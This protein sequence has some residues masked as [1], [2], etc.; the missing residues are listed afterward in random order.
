MATTVSTPWRLSNRRSHSLPSSTHHPFSSAHRTPSLLRTPSLP[1]GCDHNSTQCISMT[2]VGI[3][4]SVAGNIIISCACRNGFVADPSD[5][6]RCLNA[7]RKI[8][9]SES[10]KSHEVQHAPSALPTLLP[11]SATLAPTLAPTYEPCPDGD[12]GCDPISTRCRSVSADNYAFTTC[13]CIDG[14]TQSSNST[15]RC[16]MLTPSPTAQPRPYNPSSA[17]W[18][19]APSPKPLDSTGMG[20]MYGQQ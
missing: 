1:S 19:P 15:L 7:T 10:E 2:L 4:D 16:A 6:S 8:S 17:L 11:T 13:Q 14:F 18:M 5:G 3:D 12:H 20:S 9:G